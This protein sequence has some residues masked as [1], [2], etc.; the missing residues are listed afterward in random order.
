MALELRELQLLPLGGDVL[1]VGKL[2]EQDGVDME[3]FRTVAIGAVAGIATGQPQ[4]LKRKQSLVR[5][6]LEQD[7]ILAGEADRLTRRGFHHREITGLHK[8][9]G[10][11]LLEMLEEHLVFGGAEVEKICVLLVVCTADSFHGVGLFQIVVDVERKSGSLLPMQKKS[12]QIYQVTHTASGKV[13]VGRTTTSTELRWKRHCWAA[14]KA[15]TRLGR[16]INKYG[17][18]AFELSTLET[19]THEDAPHREVFWIKTLQATD[20]EKGYNFSC[21]SNGSRGMLSIETR[22]K[23]G[24]ASKKYWNSLSPE[25][26]TE[27]L[28]G[29]LAGIE[30]SEE[31]KSKLST[32]KTGQSSAVV[33]TSKFVGVCC[34]E[35]GGRT[36]WR[37]T[38]YHRE[39]RQERSVASEVEAARCYDRLALAL[40]GEDTPLNFP[41]FREEYLKEDL[42]GYLL[43][44]KKP[45]SRYLY[46]SYHLR[47]GRWCVFYRGKFRGKRRTEEE[48]VALAAEAAGVSTSQLLRA[49]KPTS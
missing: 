27:T 4:L 26:R 34:R 15:N 1:L 40:H 3:D 39:T 2:L 47:S 12:S 31:H 25:E 29:R 48:A 17:K 19:A 44:V 10:L 13:Y 24:A 41:D 23:L 21:G 37:A 46:V 9:L 18:S 33:K 43:A 11:F 30:K 7:V 35:K 42:Q 49:C 8:Q 38:C 45:A 20:P 16:E 14:K 5:G 32:S 6:G 36:Y 28:R 22:S